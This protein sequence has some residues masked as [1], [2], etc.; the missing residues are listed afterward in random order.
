M[1][2][3]SSQTDIRVIAVGNFEVFNLNEFAKLSLADAVFVYILK[4][5][6]TPPPPVSFDLIPLHVNDSADI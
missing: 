2:R 4:S 5:T 3:H 1:Q 6:F